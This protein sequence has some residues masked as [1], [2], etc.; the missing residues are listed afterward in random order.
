MPPDYTVP[1]K[2]PIYRPHPA[3]PLFIRINFVRADLLLNRP[4]KD[5]FIENG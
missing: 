1:V 3:I 2:N 5:R 4:D